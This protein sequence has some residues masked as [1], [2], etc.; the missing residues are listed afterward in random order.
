MFDFRF[1][2]DNWK[3]TN[4]LVLNLAGIEMIY[5]ICV[6]PVV[7]I[8]FYN[9]GRSAMLTRE[10]CT[11]FVNFRH[12]LD[13]YDA[14]TMGFLALSTCILVTRRSSFVNRVGTKALSAIVIAIIFAMTVVT[15]LAINMH[16]RGK[17]TKFDLEKKMFARF[18]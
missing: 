15:V 6:L 5:C 16:V 14:N 4:V 12:F 13:Y 11:I 1:G 2:F 3:V 7:S 18:V 8:Q 17:M 10:F 9:R